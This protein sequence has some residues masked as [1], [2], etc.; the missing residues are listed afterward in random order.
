[1]GSK[2]N[3]TKIILDLLKNDFNISNNQFRKC[4]NVREQTITNWKNGSVKPNKTN[5]EDI[6]NHLPSLLETE[7]NKNRFLERLQDNFN[8]ENND[9]FCLIRDYTSI[10]SLLNYLYKEY[11]KDLKKDKLSDLINNSESN[12]QLRQIIINKFKINENKTPNFQVEEIEGTNKS[13]L[14]KCFEM[15]LNLEHCLILK[16]RGKDNKYTYR[17]L[18]NYNLNEDEYESIGDI[19]DAKD[20]FRTHDLNMMILFSNV[21]IPEK[22]IYISMRQ[23]N[24][25]IEHLDLQEI[26]DKK[27]SKDYIYV[28]EIDKEKERIA[29]KYSDIILGK[30]SKYY[31]V[32]FKNLLFK[33]EITLPDKYV[34]NY[35]FWEAKFATRHHINFQTERIKVL[36][37]EDKQGKD[38]RVA[39]AIGFLSFP[40]ILKLA[41]LFKKIY[42]LD[43]SQESIN[44]Y[45]RLLQNNNSK[46]KDKITYILFTSGMFEFITTSYALYNSIDFIMLGTGEGSFIKH[47]R[48]YYLICN[49]WLKKGGQIYF[50][51]FNTE[52]LYDYTDKLILKENFDFIP[53]LNEKRAIAFFPNSSVKYELYCES[54]RCDELKS[55]TEEYFSIQTLFSYPLASVLHGFNKNLQNILKELDKAYSSKGFLTKTFSNCRGFYIDGLFYKPIGNLLENFKFKDERLE[56]IEVNNS[57]E[58]KEKFLKTLLIIEKNKNP[59]NKTISDLLQSNETICI[60]SIILPSNKRLPENNNGICLGGNIYRLLDIIEINLLG[61]EYINISPFFKINSDK[62]VVKKYYDIDINKP[63]KSKKSYVYIGDGNRNSRYKVK[64]EHITKLLEDNGYEIVE[65]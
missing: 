39:L 35:I 40:I 28:E 22:D 64:Q 51:F 58:Y 56:Y 5:I 8:E 38:E 47:L 50:S 53:I 27:C 1:M 4:I 2:K 13:V 61:L 17:I 36:L 42:L 29:N 3:I 30:I 46:L 32:I 45:E 23:N 12:L 6:C 24:V 15:K 65:F 33:N 60:Y 52:F 25:Y 31:A 55:V 63:I 9:I 49:Q 57:M 11:E 18:V 7:D 59:K 26:E 10:T 41:K 62:V 54:K 37:N 34:D 48:P 21:I 44:Y 20:T 43:N 19:K 16:F 14:K